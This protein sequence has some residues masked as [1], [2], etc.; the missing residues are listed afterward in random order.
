MV[1]NGLRLRTAAAAGVKPP[2]QVPVAA[3]ANPSRGDNGYSE[4]ARAL[5]VAAR[6]AGIDL[7]ILN[8]APSARTLPRYTARHREK[9]HMRRMARS[10]NRRRHG[11]C[12]GLPLLLLAVYRAAFPK[13]ERAEVAAFLWR[14]HTGHLPDPHLYTATEITRAE[15]ILG[16]NRKKTTNV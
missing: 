3:S 11:L 12:H 2:P 14:A 7:S 15:N 6:Q 10:G 8:E 9:G 5:A 16:L 1:N 13:A 4:D